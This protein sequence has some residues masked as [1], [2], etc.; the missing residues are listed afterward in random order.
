M[1]CAFRISADQ[2]VIVLFGI[3]QLDITQR[4]Q[5]FSIST[6]VRQRSRSCFS[7]RLRGWGLD[8]FDSPFTG[9]GV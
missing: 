9:L 5:V 1:V 4:G 2:R 8:C 6:V 7:P 3:T